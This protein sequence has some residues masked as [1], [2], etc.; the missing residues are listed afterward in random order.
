MTTRSIARGIACGSRGGSA[1]SDNIEFSYCK[2]AKDVAETTSD[3]SFATLKLSDTETDY[4]SIN[5]SAARNS[6]YLLSDNVTNDSSVSQLEPWYYA[7]YHHHLCD[8]S[9]SHDE[10]AVSLGSNDSI[11]DIF[12]LRQ[13]PPL[14]LSLIPDS[15][16]TPI[17]TPLKRTYLETYP[18]HDTVLNSTTIN[19]SIDGTDNTDDDLLG[20]R[21][22]VSLADLSAISNDS[23]ILMEPAI[24]SPPAK[25]RAT[26]NC[27]KCCYQLCLS[28]LTVSEVDN[29]LQYFNSKS[30]ADQ[31]QF[32]LDSFRVISN[33]ETTQHIICGKRV[34]KE[35]YIRILQIS[36]KRY[37]RILEVFKS[38]PTVKM[39]RKPVI[40]LESTKVL[41]AKA[42]LTRYFNRIGD[43]MPHMNQVHL[44]HG[45]T[46]RDVHYM[47]KSQLQQQG[48]SM[49]ISLSH[50]YDVWNRPRPIMLA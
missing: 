44:P 41:E 18:S 29:A 48:L 40:R 32:L 37:D 1:G 49:I 50:F 38:N 11:C 10:D 22:Y 15:H 30:I 3:S 9:S 14:D 12:Q 39:R 42:W 28:N 7:T 4:E 36:G 19:A 23:L 24:L 20:N 27:I 46:K 31:N 34:C 33:Q 21:S 5:D 8:V 45:L 47:M 13:P 25:K 17:S 26:V 43:S 6:S 16:S 2:I 35:A